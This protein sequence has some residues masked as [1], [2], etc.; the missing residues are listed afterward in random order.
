MLTERQT[1][2]EEEVTF[3]Q[4]IASMLSKKLFGSFPLNPG[5]NISQKSDESNFVLN[6]VLTEIFFEKKVSSQDNLM[7]KTQK[8]I[9]LKQIFFLKIVRD[10]IIPNGDIL[11][12][13]DPILSSYQRSWPNK[14]PPL[15]NQLGLV[16]PIVKILI[17]LVPPSN[18][19]LAIDNFSSPLLRAV[20][21]CCLYDQLEPDVLDRIVKVLHDSY[22]DGYIPITDHFSFF[23]T[24][25]A[26]FRVVRGDLAIESNEGRDTTFKALTDC[27]LIFVTNGVLYTLDSKPTRLSDSS[28][29]TL[30]EFLPVYLIDIVNC[31]PEDKDKPS[32]LHLQP[33]F[34]YLV[35]CFF[36]FDRVGILS[37]EKLCGGNTRHRT[38]ARKRSL[39][40]DRTRVPFGR[41]IATEHPFRSVATQRP[42]ACSA[43]SLRN[44]RTRVP[45]GRYATELGYIATEH[46][47]RSV[48]T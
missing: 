31:I 35:P 28:L 24:L 38:R 43:R 41:Y 19:A 13:N 18:P 22:K 29:T 27:V 25:I 33:C 14:L 42:N 39:R 40:N 7:Q 30:S 37:Y 26:R 32:D 1:S 6:G 17:P 48:A 12:F 45:L 2:Y 34:Y 8:Y 9:F 3:D 4:D 21:L 5:N 20:A 46:P 23:I 10:L 16:P 11:Y 36:L 47:F 15:L 44:D